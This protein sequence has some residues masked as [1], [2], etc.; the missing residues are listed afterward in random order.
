[1]GSR[2]SA[3]EQR[4]WEK[5]SREKGCNGAVKVRRSNIGNEPWEELWAGP[6]LVLSTASRFLL[7]EKRLLKSKGY[8]SPGNQ[9]RRGQ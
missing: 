5:C 3:R 8:M 4:L 6:R 9:Q 1:M 2:S 7:T